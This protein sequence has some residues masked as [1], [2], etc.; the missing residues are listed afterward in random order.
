MTTH[1]YFVEVV[2]RNALPIPLTYLLASAR[3]S[4][5]LALGSESRVEVEADFSRFCAGCS[6]WLSSYSIPKV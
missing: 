3:W 1:F 4:G 2:P 5:Y 6:G